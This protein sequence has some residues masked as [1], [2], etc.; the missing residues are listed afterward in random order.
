MAAKVAEECSTTRV[1]T[2]LAHRWRHLAEIH[3]APR[4]LWHALVSA[5]LDGSWTVEATR[6]S[7]KRERH[8]RLLSEAF[9]SV[10]EHEPAG[11][12]CHP[13][14]DSHGSRG[15]ST[16]LDLTRFLAPHMKPEFGSGS[17]SSTLSGAAATSAGRFSLAREDGVGRGAIPFAALSSRSRSALA[18]A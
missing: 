17:R 11:A 14:C 3:A 8:P 1:V 15:D 9:A 2:D 6:K 12:R 4:W 5:M 10:H 7:R 16:G 13:L 18:A